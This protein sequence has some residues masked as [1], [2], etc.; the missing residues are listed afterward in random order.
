[1]SLTSRLPA[2]LMA[3]LLTQFVV[4]VSVS[5]VRPVSSYRLLAIGADATAVG[6]VAAAFALPAMMLALPLGRWTDGAEVP[7][8][9]LV[10]GS[11]SAALAALMLSRSG[12]VVE[13]GLWTGLLGIGHLLVVVGAQSLVAADD[14]GADG[15]LAAFGWLTLAAALGQTAGPLLGGYL[16]EASGSTPTSDS[17]AF[18]LSTAAVIGVLGVPVSLAALRVPRRPRDHERV[19]AG[20]GSARTLLRIAGVPTALLASFGAKGSVDLLSAFLPL[21]GTQIGLPP[22]TVGVLLGVSAASSIVARIAMP[23]L[24]RRTRPVRL[25]AATTAASAVCILA[26]PLGRDAFLLGVLLAALGFLLALAQTVTM[27]W[28][29]ALVP[30]ANSG[31]ALGLRLAGNRVGQVSVP[32]VA[33]LLAGPAGVPAM[34]YVLAATLGAIACVIVR[35]EATTR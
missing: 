11:A 24:V 35:S 30:A 25:L 34:F 33:G 22:R 1:M 5:L 23:A 15:G 17:T 28:V 27:V 6:L 4:Q 14:S 13:L 19:V 10:L 12:S 20:A 16:S 9:V 8:R 26:V 21:L 29:V 32:G 18:A 31:A 7:G 2:W 3:V